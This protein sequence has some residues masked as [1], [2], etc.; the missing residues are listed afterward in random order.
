MEEESWNN[1]WERRRERN[2][3]TSPVSL[4]PTMPTTDQSQLEARWQG[5]LETTAWSGGLA[6][7]HIEQHRGSRERNLGQRGHGPVL[8]A[9]IRPSVASK[10]LLSNNECLTPPW[11]SQ[12]V[13]WFENN[14]ER[15]ENLVLIGL[16]K[17]TY[18]LLKWLL[19][20]GTPTYGSIG[21][22]FKYAH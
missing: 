4:L 12:D 19:W 8:D 17:Q 14:I 7:R 2:V 22:I 21:I 16:L 18:C 3:L 1:S 9:F 11:W 20:R 10:N 6:P 15:G 5:S 13:H